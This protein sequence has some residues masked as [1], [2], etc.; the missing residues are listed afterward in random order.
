MKAV[1]KIGNSD[2][3]CNICD[4]K[5]DYVVN[6]NFYCIKHYVSEYYR[7]NIPCLMTQLDMLIDELDNG[8]KLSDDEE[9]FLRTI[10]KELPEVVDEFPR[11]FE[12]ELD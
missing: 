8:K 5:A 11:I 10:E 7:D 3:K 12:E 1:Y 4:N 9:K 2:K 6:S